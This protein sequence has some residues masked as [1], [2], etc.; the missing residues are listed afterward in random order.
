MRVFVLQA[1]AVDIL[2]HLLKFK[3]TKFI[4]VFFGSNMT[5][6]LE[7]RCW[8]LCPPCFLVLTR[9]KGNKTSHV[10]K[11][12][13]NFLMRQKVPRFPDFPVP[14]IVFVYFYLIWNTGFPVI[15]IKSKQIWAGNA[16]F[17][18]YAML[19]FICLVLLNGHKRDVISS[20]YPRSR[21]KLLYHL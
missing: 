19:I 10:F 7:A 9:T 8:V 20:F 6:R 1:F 14:A 18:R 21:Q 17:S 11:T 2:L 15:W 4:K 3:F 5:E 12:A 13:K 16:S